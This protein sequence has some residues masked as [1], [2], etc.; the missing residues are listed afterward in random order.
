VIWLSLLSLLAFSCEDLGVGININGGWAIYR[1]KDPSITSYQ[2][3]NVP[4]SDLTL[5]RVPFIAARDIR[6]YDWKTH[7]FECSAQA[8]SLFDSLSRN[9][10]SVFGVPFVVTVDRKPIYLGSFWWM[11]SSITPWCPFIGVTFPV[12]NDKPTAWTIQLDPL[13]QGYDPRSDKR[14]YYSLKAS[15]LLTN[16]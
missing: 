9:C 11:Y 13:Y 2:I 5:A 12:G 6:S 3:R 15:G 1:L 8:T 14:I 10:G 4:L 16:E 7:T